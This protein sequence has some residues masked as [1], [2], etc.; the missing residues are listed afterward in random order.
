[1]R[2]IVIPDRLA[3]D[4]GMGSRVGRPGAER[5]FTF[6]LTLAGPVLR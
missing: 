3:F 2:F 1:V 6:G 4:A 5:Y